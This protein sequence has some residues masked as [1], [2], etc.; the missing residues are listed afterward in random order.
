MLNEP[1]WG[2]LLS[3]I[4]KRFVE[5]GPAFYWGISKGEVPLLELCIQAPTWNDLTR[6]KEAKHGLLKHE[7]LHLVFRHPLLAHS[8]TDTRRYNL[9]CDWAVNQYL[10]PAQRSDTTKSIANFSD[11][12]LLPFKSADYYYQTLGQWMQIDQELEKAI[13]S[14][15]SNPSHKSWYLQFANLSPI[16]R[17]ILSAGIDQ[18]IQQTIERVGEATLMHWPS[19]LRLYLVNRKTSQRSVHNWR[20]ILRLFIGRHRTTRLKHSIR[21]PSKRYGTTPGLRLQQRQ[22]ILV[23]LDTS[24]SIQ[25]NDFYAFFREIHQLWK[26]GAKVDIMECDTQIRSQYTYQGH[27]PPFV[28]GRGG[29]NFDP[30]VRWAND[31][32]H[33]DAIIYFTD[34][35]APTLQE[36]SRYPILWVLNQRNSGNWE[37]SQGT[38]V[39]MKK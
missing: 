6:K 34:G 24:G 30:P 25:E 20:R 9:A 16:E 23:A 8:Y 38:P 10:P 7:L 19:A 3:G 35:Q 36:K 39:W 5:E 15:P 37:Q 33:L 27:P 31:H 1:F 29:S 18:L 32:H 2:H 26:L 21:R 17:D 4:P 28:M 22:K 13:A 12:K 14:F 11:E